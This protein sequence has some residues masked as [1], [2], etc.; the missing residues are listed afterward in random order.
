ME[1][2]MNKKHLSLALAALLFTA[3]G[4][5]S[6][7]SKKN[8]GKGS[9]DFSQYF[10]KESMSKGYIVRKQYDDGTPKTTL[11]NETFEVVGQ[12]ITTRVNSKVVEKVVITDKNITITNFS[13][14][15]NS[16]D[17]VNRMYRKM[18][19]GDTLFSEK[20]ESTETNDLGKISTSATYSCMVKSKEKKFEK[21]DYLY[22]GDLLKIEC[23][24][25]GIKIYEI[26]QAILDAGLASD[27]NGTHETYDKS[28]VY[29]QKDLG[30]VVTI[31][32]DCI[33]NGKTLTIINDKAKSS[34]CV[35]TRSFKEFYVEQ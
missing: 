4:G 1:I 20:I 25:K 24:D 26:K 28:Y 12:T 23:I 11:R 16:K 27:L 30:K 10:P 15:E 34:E 33:T 8:D 32:D 21:G 35:Q 6:S 2:L 9:I 29:W 17:N 18:D 14:D 22:E 13:E 3:C 31:N 19:I 7:S 5:N